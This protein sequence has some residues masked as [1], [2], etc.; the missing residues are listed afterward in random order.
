MPYSKWAKWAMGTES[1][2]SFATLALLV[3]RAVNIARG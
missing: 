1:V 3:A 2:L